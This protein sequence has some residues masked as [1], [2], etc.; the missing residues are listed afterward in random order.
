[1]PDIDNPEVRTFC[2]E[3][4]RRLADKAAAYYYAANALI[5]EW[6]ATDMGS[7]IPDSGDLIIDGS[8]TDGRSPITGANVR[9]LKEHVELMVADLQANNKA[10]LAVLLKI[11]VNGSP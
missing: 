2:N 10:K 5:D 11:E 7:K 9:S 1:M 6:E 3:G 4:I 8:A